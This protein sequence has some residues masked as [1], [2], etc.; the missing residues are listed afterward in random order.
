MPRDLLQEI[1]TSK[2]RDL[3]AQ[4]PT[5]AR[6]KAWKPP[7]PGEEALQDPDFLAQ[8]FD[9]SE[10]AIMALSGGTLGAIKGGARAILPGAFDW[11]TMGIPKALRNVPAAGRALIR[12]MGAKELEKSIPAEVAGVRM[13]SPPP[14]LPFPIASAPIRAMETRAA[15]LGKGAEKPGFA[16]TAD[17][18]IRDRALRESGLTPLPPLSK[19]LPKK[20]PF[21]R[22]AEDMLAEREARITP[23]GRKQPLTQTPPTPPPPIPTTDLDSLKET[24]KGIPL[25]TGVEER[26][27]LGAQ[28][29]AR[30]ASIK[31]NIAGGW[32]WLKGYS[33]GIWSSYVS[34]PIVTDYK[35]ALGEYMA[36]RT[37]HEMKVDKFAHEAVSKFS[38]LER[39]AMVNYL[40]AGGDLKLLC[41][42]AA[43]AKNP[44]LK[45]GY[46]AAQSLSPD[47]ITFVEDTRKYFSSKLDELISSGLLDHGVENY[48]FHIF[49]RDP[50]KAKTLVNALKGEANLSVLD[51]N[52][53]FLKQR[54]FHTYADAEAQDWVPKNKD[55]GYLISTY[56]KSFGEA[57]HSRTFI[58]S[59]KELK[60]PDGR[61]L[62]MASG[63]RNTMKDEIRGAMTKL[64]A[65]GEVSK[66]ARRRLMIKMERKHKE[67][68]QG[69]G[70]IK[71][72]ALNNLLVHPALT[73][74]LTRPGRAKL[75]YPNLEN[76]LL[77][78]SIRRHPV[79][80][81]ALEVAATA[82]GI[83]LSMIPVP[84]HQV[85]TG[86]HAVFHMVDPAVTL[87]PFEE[88]IA[89]P[90]SRELVS[91]GLMVHS[92]HALQEFG[93]GIAATGAL[94]DII[95]FTKKYGEYLFSDYIP[96]L[97]LAMAHKAVA[98]N[99]GWYGGKLS[100][101]Q[102]LELSA[103]QSNAAFGELNYE[104]MG[105]N[106]TMQ[107]ILK[108]M[109]FAPDF[110][111]ARMRFTG[112]ALQPWGKEQLY[113]LLRASI[114]MFGVARVLN[115]VTNNGDM[116][117]REP[118]GWVIGD[119][120]HSIRSIPGD[121]QHLYDRPRSFVYY[122][123]NPT[124]VR[125][126]IEG[127]T[128]RDFLGRK[129]TIA[130]QA[131]D[132]FTSQTPILTSN[133]ARE[134][135]EKGLNGDLYNAFMNSVLQ[136]ISVTRYQMKQGTVSKKRLGG[137]KRSLR[138]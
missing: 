137:L 121:L 48:A 1:E 4:T 28:A 81:M 77:S 135:T 98:D 102:I 7:Q 65:K 46:E 123:L 2:G 92:S 91:R 5:F 34:P 51:K 36:A 63:V 18:L 116:K 128:G 31:G 56:E 127:V 104:W 119:Y 50:S 80:R 9:P 74:P 22:T 20:P 130:Q 78:S 84:F 26:M 72:P 66:E 68:I 47:A 73:Q 138:R 58:D 44:M 25:N 101:D 126:G 131:E 62:L 10:L 105:R 97:K 76:V 122:R 125:T 109:L 38:R 124:T 113:A 94:G 110:L 8:F 75:G 59:L 112:Q 108:L 118:F 13:P 54:F 42:R 55:L 40:E 53:A 129:R 29:A 114:G 83:I 87:R 24:L 88:M 43:A 57:L 133:V 69:Y 99:L 61:P 15:D 16:K 117:W 6:R 136:S 17:D 132:F 23:K 85:Q 115:A 30:A 39:E 106:K 3:L 120:V 12:G 33:A 49:E 103:S 82:K 60:G 45:K 89:E 100:R 93:E 37:F 111:E 32:E 67:L 14:S 134:L 90:L 71:H 21:M 11:A 19:K 95:P 35:R 70:E 96:R 79:G 64:K 86:L 52:P 107:D 27:K 41:E